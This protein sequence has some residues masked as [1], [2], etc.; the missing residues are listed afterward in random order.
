MEPLIPHWIQVF[1]LAGI[2]ALTVLVPLKVLSEMTRSSRDRTRKA[3]DL[4]ERLRERVGEAVYEGGFLV[5][6]RIRVKHDGRKAVLIPD[7]EDELRILV[8]APIAPPFPLVVRTKG[9]LVLPFAVEGWRL[10]PRLRTFDPTLDDSLAVYADGAF[11]AYVRDLALDGLPAGG[12][13]NGLAESLIVLRRVPGV[14][15]FELRLSPSG[16]LRLRFEL[17][18]ADLLHRPD[19][20]EAVLHHAFSIYDRLVAS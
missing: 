5:P 10:L 8:E 16:G 17:R 4:A 14:W 18:S 3:K 19:E 9:A 1:V 20:L 15:A 6:P 7:D 11:G 12:K 13:P 2:A